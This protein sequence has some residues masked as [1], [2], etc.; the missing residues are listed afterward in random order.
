MKFPPLRLLVLDTETTGFVPK[1]HRVIEYAS[2]LVEGGKVVKEYEQLLSLPEGAEIPDVVQMLTRIY[3][4]DLIDKPTFETIQPTI[5]TM[6]TDDTIIVGQ[7]VKFDI[8]MLKGEG[9]DL[10]GRPS[11][12]TAMLASIV[13]P[14]LASYSL[15]YVSKALKLD[16][17]PHHRAL[18]DVRATVQF[19]SACFERLE[20]LPLE[21]IEKI[22]E[23]AARGPEGYKRFFLGLGSGGTAKPTWLT[24]AR[25]ALPDT[26][27]IDIESP[28][29]GTVQLREE[30]IDAAFISSVLA[31]LTGRTWCAVK[32]IEAAVGRHAGTQ[33][34]TV[35]YPPEFLL[36]QSSK[37]TFLEQQEFTADELTLAIKLLLYP[38]TFRSELPIH[39]EEYAVFAGKLAAAPDSPEYA[40]LQKKAVEGPTILSHEHLLSLT[41]DAGH[42]LPND[43]SLLIDD[44]SMLEDTATSAFGW[45]CYIPSLRASSQGNELL[46]KC[47]DLIE[48]FAERVRADMSLRYL[49]V[50]DLESR[51]CTELKKTLESV[52][53]EPM[54]PQ[55]RRAI[56]ELQQIL[57]PQNLSGRFAWIEAMKDGSKAIKSVPEDIAALLAD[58]LYSSTKTT[59]LIPPN[60]SET[61]ATIL[62]SH[63]PHALLSSAL[64][65]PT[66]SLSIPVGV[67]LDSV[68]H[69]PKG[70]SIVIVPSKRVLDDIFVRYT[71]VLEKKGVTLLCQGFSGGA[72]RMQAEFIIAAEPAVMVMTPWMYEGCDLAPEMVD[73]L[74]LQ[75]LPFDH[76]AHAVVSRRALR[77][78][79][80]FSEY[81]LPRLQHRLFRLLRTFSRHA[82]KGATFSILD[83][84]LRTKPY[85]KRTAAYLES[86]FAPTSETQQATMSV[87]S[88]KKKTDE[89]QM[90][91]L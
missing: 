35:L 11:I 30:P 57:D 48:L 89:D 53:D 3:P 9:L 6:L 77:F 13:F 90:A 88:K 81:S 23:Y 66:F 63:T 42:S 84:R 2:A 40:L 29:T 34:L 4:E 21:D 67:S 58:R 31:G 80:G 15:G 74:F 22:K 56:V 87:T 75:S 86:F 54:P 64:P 7:N 37:K 24:S 73:Q 10:T 12:D 91:L 55:A 33:N 41:E 20:E 85:G 25:T 45:S 76:P 14:E 62:P 72:S 52:I 70:K 39:G 46:T 18:G 51:D 61:L 28:E 17:T 38:C 49:A 50:S 8:G 69:E 82:K 5:E 60:S 79:D 44:A 16:H 65:F 78:R 27:T 36:S 59:L 71:E 26:Q 47:V 43:L 1:T 32:N 68:F 19:L 83:D